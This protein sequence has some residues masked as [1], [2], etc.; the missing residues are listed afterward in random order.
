MKMTL[1]IGFYLYSLPLLSVREV[2]DCV[3]L[4]GDIRYRV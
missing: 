2:D 1:T 3:D 4:G